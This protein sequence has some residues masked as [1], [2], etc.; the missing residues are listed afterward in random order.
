MNIKTERLL[1]REL[2][3]GDAFDFYML[4][5]DPEVLQY[6]GDKAFSDVEA[7]IAFLKGY[8]QYIRYGVGRLAVMRKAD[9]AFLGWC[10][11]RYDPEN[12]AYDIGFRFF[13]K[14]WHNGYA[15]EAATAC[16]SYGFSKMKIANIIGRAMKE[17]YAS[18]QV[19]QKLGM[20]YVGDFSCQDKVGVLYRI[21]RPT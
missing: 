12:E 14:Y 9:D 4:N 1:L 16:I 6:T 2:N 20:E 15:T 11:L 13:K 17:N 7:A 21:T 18:V 3:A 19:L 10:G 8:D 5:E